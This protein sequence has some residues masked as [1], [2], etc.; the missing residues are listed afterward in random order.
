MKGVWTIRKDSPDPLFYFL[1][2]KMFRTADGLGMQIAMA[3]TKA[4][5]T[6]TELAH[7]LGTSGIC[8]SNWERG[9][10][11]P[12]E[13]FMRKLTKILN[14]NPNALRLYTLGMNKPGGRHDR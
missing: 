12:Q 3:R 13:R 4:R 8:I 6:Q 7:I 5:L 2:A 9:R 1:G 11:K 10:N 14:M